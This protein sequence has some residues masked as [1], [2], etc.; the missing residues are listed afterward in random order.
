MYLAPS[1]GLIA[2]SQRDLL[3]FALHRPESLAEARALLAEAPERLVIHAG[4][5]DLFAQ[6]REGL[7]FSALLSIGGIEELKTI[8][9]SGATMRIGA[10]VTHM[11]AA[12]HSE[13][14]RIPGLAEAWRS[15]A[16]IRIRWT[17]TMGGN[18]M[19]RRP[20]YELATLFS[21][22]DARLFF[23]NARGE[24]ELSIVDFLVHGVEP[25]ALLTHVTIDTSAAPSLLYDRS[26]RPQ[27]TL[28]T[29]QTRQTRRAVIATQY[30]WPVVLE[31]DRSL[32]PAEAAS[33][34][35]THLRPDFADATA[36]NEW[37][38][39]AGQVLFRRHLE[40][41]GAE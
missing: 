33:S 12:R 13:L 18:L 36:P 15:I 39:K 23:I 20:R 40:R 30:L 10:L 34:A 27:M 9:T 6:I 31:A 4:G 25:G 22:L 8:T 2:R 32:T 17:A 7:D 26:F 38:R 5:T 37:L 16:T 21:A 29:A 28:A 3:P 41:L 1:A 11:D 14:A 35:F 19:A 24:F